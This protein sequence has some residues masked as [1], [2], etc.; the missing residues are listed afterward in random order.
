MREGARQMGTKLT[1]TW[2]QVWR[3]QR[4]NHALE[5]SGVAVGAALVAVALLLAVQLI[6]TPGMQ[7]TLDCAVA[8]VLGGDGCAGADAG[9]NGVGG[10]AAAQ[11][12]GAAPSTSDGPSGART[13]ASIGLD[14][15]PVVGEI[16][17]LIEVFTGTDL[18]T[19]EDLGW[20]RFAGLAGLV[21]LNEIKLLRHGDE[22]VDLV[23]R[24]DDVLDTGGD[25]AR[26]TDDV[27]PPC[28]LERAPSGRSAGLAAPLALTNRAGNSTRIG[29]PGEAYHTRYDYNFLV[30][31]TQSF[32]VSIGN[33]QVQNCAE[34]IKALDAGLPN[35]NGAGPTSGYLFDSDGNMI[36]D[37]I[38]SGNT[39]SLPPAQRSMIRDPDRILPSKG[40]LEFLHHVESKVA[41]H[42]Q[43]N[44]I[45]NATLVLNNHPC[46]GPISCSR[47]L[48]HLLPEGSTLRVIVPDGFD[49]RGP[50]DDIFKGK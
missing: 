5:A 34:V 50:F 47:W 9:A 36:G 3:E 6:T 31:G 15:I 26:R 22:V 1:S 27:I 29:K 16:K 48:E 41:R 12:S 23:Q 32:D 4:G 25:V 20:W 44:S 18:V 11:P 49:A 35:R 14:V 33:L 2:Q 40:R 45:S 8:I 19:G 28:R 13:A 24:G 10:G 46:S 17:G 37:M 42:M 43:E 30:K 38:V 39:V 21:G 7:R